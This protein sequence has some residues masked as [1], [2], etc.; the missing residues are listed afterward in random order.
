MALWPLVDRKRFYCSFLCL[1]NL[2]MGF[3]SSSPGTVFSSKAHNVVFIFFIV[4][5]KS[6]EFA[7]LI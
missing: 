2:G 4:R 3:E 6:K 1:T 5:E 7:T